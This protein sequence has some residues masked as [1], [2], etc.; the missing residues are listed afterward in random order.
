MDN[1][2]T[3]WHLLERFWE[4]VRRRMRRVAQLRIE[5]DYWKGRVE[6][7]ERDLHRLRGGL[8]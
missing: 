8:T 5:R 1:W 3:R 2:L 4:P 7:A 6:V